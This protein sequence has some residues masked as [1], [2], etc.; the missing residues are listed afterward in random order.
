MYIV[1]IQHPNSNGI[2]LFSVP[3][4]IALSKGQKVKCM[5]SRGEQ[6]GTCVEDSKVIDDKALEY[7]A[8]VAQYKL[9][10]MPVLGIWGYQEF[11]KPGQEVDDTAIVKEPEVV[12][13]LCVKDWDPGK[14]LSKGKVYKTDSAGCFRFD[15]GLKS[16][17]YTSGFKRTCP[18]MCSCLV[19]LVKRPAKV[20]EWVRVAKAADDHAPPLF[21]GMVLRCEILYGNDAIGAKGWFFVWVRVRSH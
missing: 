4:G 1:K 6:D 14:T 19:P 9:P 11:K 12:K 21:D 18:R 15:D 16:L 2:Y 3:N 8:A 20:E 17:P 10:L 7:L 5:T 13:L